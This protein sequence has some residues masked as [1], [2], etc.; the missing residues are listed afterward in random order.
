MKKVINKTS[1]KIMA[2][3]IFVILAILFVPF[4]RGSNLVRII[5]DKIDYLALSPER[6]E[7]YDKMKIEYLNIKSRI[8]GTEPFNS[9][10][11]SNANGVDVSDKDDYV[12]TFDVMK[13]TVELGISPNTMHSGVTNSSVYEGGVIKVRAKLPN[14]G[15]PTLMRWEQDAW[16]QN[17]SYSNDKTEIYAEYHVPTGVS[18][19]NANQKL[20]FTI[21][22]GGYKKE[23][24][25]EMAP[26]FEV[27]ME[28]NKPDD[29]T[30][31]ASS[32]TTKDNRNTIISGKVSLDTTI[33]DS[34]YIYSGTVNNQKGHYVTYGLG[35]SLY[36][37]V[38]I[39]SDLRGVEYPSGDIIIDLTS[40]YKARNI[41]TDEE[42]IEVNENN[43]NGPLNNT[44]LVAY[45]VN[46]VDNSSYYPTSRVYTRNLPYGV[47]SSAI[48]TVNSGTMAYSMS[49]E[50]SQMKFSGYDAKGPYPTR[51]VVA[52]PSTVTYSS[53]IG[54]FAEG[55]VQVFVPYY[56]NDSRYEYD[57]SY[58]VSVKDIKYK[59]TNGEDYNIQV[60]NMANRNNKTVAIGFTKRVTGSFYVASMLSSNNSESRDG[61]ASGFLGQT[62]TPTFTLM[63][64]DGP[65]EGGAER[66][67][68]WDNNYFSYVAKSL[69]TF[70]TTELGFQIPSDS[71][72]V[73]QYG[74]YKDD[75]TNGITGDAPLNNAKK[76]QFDWYAT[77]AEATSHGRIAAIYGFDSDV[78]GNRVHRQIRLN[79][80]ITN[81]S[82]YIGS[83]GAI[84]HRTIIYGDAAK[85]KVFTP[86]LGTN[87][88]KTAY[89]ETGTVTTTH[90]PYNIG[91]SVL[92]IGLKSSIITS[93]EDKDSEGKTK[94]AYDIQDGS[95]NLVVKPSLTNGKSASNE[96]PKK[97]GIIVKTVLPKGLSYQIASANKDPK[98][99]TI[100]GD[101]T[102]TI[103]WEYNDW[104]VNHQAPGYPTITFAAD[105]SASLENN[106]SLN[107]KSTIYSNEDL[108][109]E[110]YRTS[111]Y[112]VVISNLAGSRASKDIDKT[113]VEKNEK[114]NVISTL[115][116]NS[117]EVLVNLKTIEI[118]PT[119][120]DENGSKFSGNYTSKIISKIEGQKVF[121]TTNRIEAIGL[122]ED[123]YGKLTIKD[124]DLENDGRWIEVG[125]GDVIPSNATAIATVLPSLAAQTEKSYIT[126][127]TPTGNK[128][129]DAYA[130]TMNMTCDNLQ[131]AIRTNTVITRVVNR[132]I[133]G[134][135]FIDKN[136]NGSYENSDELLKTS[137]VKLLDNNGNII[138]TTQTNNEGKYEF[139]S[140][141][142]GNYYVEFSIPTNYETI[143][144]G[145]SSKANSSGR[146]DLITN[147]NVVPTEALLEINNIDLGI[148]KISSKINV[149]Y[150][151]YGNSTNIFDSTEIDKYYGDS[152]NLDEDYTPTIPDNYELKEKTNNYIGT[153]SEKQIN[154]I[155]YY[156]KKDSKLTTSLTKIGTELI[157]SRKDKVKYKLTY[158]ATIEDYL[159]EATIQIIDTLPYE[160]DQTKS[161]LDGGEYNS[162]NKTITWTIPKTIG[163]IN[164]PEIVI[165]KEIE[166]LDEGIDPTTREIINTVEG[167]ITLDNN[168]R[169]IERSCETEIKIPGKIKVRYIEI[170][171]EGEETKEIIEPIENSGL[172]G[173]EI[174]TEE[175]DFEGYILEEKPETE[176][177]K[178]LEEEQEVVYKYLRIK[179]K[180]ES[181]V[182]GLGGKISG[183][184]DIYYGDDSTKDKIIIEADDG[185][186]IESIMINGKKLNIPLGKERII[187]DNFQEM[188]EN[189]LI[190]VQFKKK[191]EI[192][193]P[194][195]G[196]ILTIISILVVISILIYTF[197]YNKK[198]IHN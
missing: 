173:E 182:R 84:V 129:E 53:K 179:L 96:D 35:V 100:N 88:R 197:I 69:S 91:A 154:I 32:K 101:G 24:T 161:N 58:Q 89:N 140:V 66:L 8:T 151:E 155:Y 67:V 40:K 57:Y 73:F 185:Y 164:E 105:I 186:E 143:E 110:I 177:Y 167:I 196:N 184:E 194:L 77:E 29:A 21:K 187:L 104:Q 47:G 145:N 50:S 109:E 163:S 112:G 127:Y 135:A 54:H 22:V 123:I 130:F 128:E 71:T 1:I 126:E 37:P 72:L 87:Y 115:G 166:L 41:T 160:I 44:S 189:K 157:E 26:E 131:A 133:R 3:I 150:E 175:K 188:K 121:Y 74:V 75:P 10:T 146:T 28:G 106:A 52:I 2:I 178:Y 113:V 144:K 17:V 148:R 124:V 81:D 99:V 27:W 138:R 180:V 83:V 195:T 34:T 119:N 79:L 183:D 36:Q 70:S 61:L 68:T 171:E 116:N 153:V 191:P 141:D 38:S 147:L 85:T 60:S 64:V 172:V 198:I 149:S 162:T 114:F 98:S 19:T 165:E 169:S 159:G 158:K 125:V 48:A 86:Y 136:R 108:R 5:K 170:N 31:S 174:T 76:D 20:S 39:F 13:Y 6:Q 16:M 56:D 78:V 107:I 11:T 193:N 12:R 97:D 15:T 94:K 134:K 152:Y 139:L 14:Q 62:I 65:Y 63:P 118:L 33:S 92:V 59:D 45:S 82:Q 181:K 51:N 190:E 95:I 43:S 25:S 137:V 46:G 132:N 7:V 122:T 168:E 176:E 80:K 93:V 55:N 120:N 102:T 9:G 117:E 18:I 30:S 142:K 156:Q 23:V 4:Y 49:G 192:K 103:E 111:Q 42:Y 90:S